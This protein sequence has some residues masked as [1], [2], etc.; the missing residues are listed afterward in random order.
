MKLE[1][2][3]KRYNKLAASPKYKSEEILGILAIR[4]GMAVADVGSGGGFYSLA[5]AKASAPD[6]VVV[7]VDTDEES[8]AYVKANA[9]SQGI[10]NLE[11][12][13]T[14]EDHL[15]LPHRK[16]DLIFMRDMF[17]HVADPETFFKSIIDYLK[18]S[19]LVVA[20]DYKKSKGFSLSASSAHRYSDP[21][22]IRE[23]MENAGLM[24]FRTFN[25]IPDQSFQVFGIKLE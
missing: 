19:G 8:L 17:H 13:V 5:F 15:E 7:A 11:T 2:K 21:E 25:F 16:F 24:Q 20:I 9:Q 4:P 14:P 18:K 22:V 1:K 10:S 3:L 12:F 6:G 23:V